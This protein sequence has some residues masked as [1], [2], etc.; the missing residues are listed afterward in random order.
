M[1]LRI[2]KRK[3]P[4]KRGPG[5]KVAIF[6][7]DICGETF[8]KKRFDREL[9]YETHR[10]SRA[11]YLEE[12]RQ[13]KTSLLVDHTCEWCGKTEKILPSNKRRFC[14]HK[15]HGAW[16]TA[17][18]LDEYVCE[19]CGETFAYSKETKIRRRFCSQRCWYDHKSR[20][21]RK[22]TTCEQCGE[23]FEQIKAGAHKFCS[24]E[25]YGNHRRDNPKLYGCT[26]EDYQ[27]LMNSPAAREK[28]Q[29]SMEQLWDDWKTG[30]R[31]HPFVGRHHT[32]STK[33]KISRH[34]IETECVSGE[35]NG[36]F[37][38][39]HTPEAR[40]KMSIAQT[41]MILNGTRKP[42]GRNF[43]KAG[44]LVTT[45]GGEIYYR[46][47][48][49]EAF[50]V[51][52]D[53]NDDIL[54]FSHEPFVIAYWDSINNKRRY[55]PDFLVEYTSGRTV[56]YEIKPA[57]F[58]NSQASQLKATAARKHCEES[59]IDGYKFLTKETLI[60]MGALNG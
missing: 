59:G 12:N 46:S 14:S 29:V 8:E 27:R 20:T 28:W 34:H 33:D 53:K 55:V 23:E 16:T 36:M 56:L 19:E 4:G 32:Q 43:H 9:K 6:K 48:W 21:E 24:V 10:C 31:Q 50:A 17:Q 13:K 25:C 45:K 47:S 44:M 1:L 49:E 42:Y 18:S 22:L 52:C 2:E 39:N 41:E 54:T 38:R 11:C 7:C 51:W 5:K 30:K 58:V 57:A 15:C 26:A 35:K 40:E 3:T 37:G 60:E